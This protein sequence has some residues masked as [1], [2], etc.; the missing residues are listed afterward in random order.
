MRSIITIRKTTTITPAELI[1][2]TVHPW[3]SV[4]TIRG[5]AAVT[6]IMIRSILISIPLSVIIH[7]TAECAR[8]GTVPIM[9]DITG[10]VIRHGSG[11]ICITTTGTAMIHGT[12]KRTT[13]MA[14]GTPQGPTVSMAAGRLE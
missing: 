12:T 11:T 14:H 2:F 4:F 6:A 1:A 9:V 13:I 10:T 7:G 8:H 3:A 5:S